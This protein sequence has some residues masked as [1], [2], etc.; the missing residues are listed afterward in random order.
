MSGDVWVGS[1]S[2]VD[3]PVNGVAEGFDKKVAYVLKRPSKVSGAKLLRKV[4]TAVS[5]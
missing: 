4:D 1:S 2:P 3:M 5:W